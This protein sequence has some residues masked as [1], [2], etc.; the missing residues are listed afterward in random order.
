MPLRTLRDALY[1]L[2]H[3]IKEFHAKAGSLAFIPC[4]GSQNV[5]LSH[6]S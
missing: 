3:T 4:D 1:R 2:I 6:R 5:L